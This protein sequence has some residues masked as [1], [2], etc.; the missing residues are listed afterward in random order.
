MFLRAASSGLLPWHNEPVGEEINL[1]F[2]LEK[3]LVVLPSVT[4]DGR[5][6]RFLFGS[7]EPRSLVDP[8]FAN[9]PSHTL[10]LNEKESLRMPCAYIDLHG[11]A[12]VIVGND[13]SGAHAVTIDY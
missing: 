5:S 1:V 8:H 12:D 4:V 2:T 11:V 3:N 6:G 9:S 13:V 10:Q 7:A